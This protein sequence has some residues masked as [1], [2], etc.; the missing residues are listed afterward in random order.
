MLVLTRKAGEELI[1]ADQIEVRILGITKGRVR[2]GI[3]A[4]N[5]MAVY[6]KEIYADIVDKNK[7]AVTAKRQS[8]GKVL[9]TILRKEA[10]SVEDNP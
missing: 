2:L 5:K 1:I 4:P 7:R 3:T 9:K 10:R 6:R 8:L